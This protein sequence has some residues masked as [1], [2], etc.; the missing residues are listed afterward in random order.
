MEAAIRPATR[1]DLPGIVAI[2]N[3]A[4]QDTTGTYDAEPHTLEQRITRQRSIPFWGRI[5]CA[6]GVP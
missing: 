1:E 4:V 5:R 6:D 2:Y 3:E